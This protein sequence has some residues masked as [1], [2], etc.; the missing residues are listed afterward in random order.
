MVLAPLHAC[1]ISCHTVLPLQR[2]GNLLPTAER[3]S[4]HIAYHRV[5]TR[6]TTRNSLEH[7]VEKEPVDF[8]RIAGSLFRVIVL[9]HALHSPVALENNH[10]TCLLTDLDLPRERSVRLSPRT[11]GCDTPTLG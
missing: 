10:L 11:L 9:R 1:R 3:R 8:D 4:L 5:L 7:A 2:I 6:P